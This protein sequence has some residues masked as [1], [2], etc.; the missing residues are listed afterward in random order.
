M[1]DRLIR[2]QFWTDPDV[3]RWSATEMLIYLGTWALAED[4][5]VIP[6]DPFTWKHT[7]LPACAEVTVESLKVFRDKMV[8]AGKYLPFTVD[9]KPYLMIASFHRHQ[10]PSHPQ[11]DGR[12]VPPGFVVISERKITFDR[13][14]YESEAARRPDVVP[15]GTRWVGD[16]QDELGTEQAPP[17]QGQTDS[18]KCSEDQVQGG[19]LGDAPEPWDLLGRLDQALPG[20]GTDLMRTFT[21]LAESKGTQAAIEALYALADQ[22]DQGHSIEDPS[23]YLATIATRLSRRDQR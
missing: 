1:R 10:K 6:D 2:K 12:P 15:L 18:N 9:S 19:P 21:S 13:T 4:T 22:I 5:G 14:G 7:I 17:N 20:H 8:E 23:A 11:Y 16:G 3:M